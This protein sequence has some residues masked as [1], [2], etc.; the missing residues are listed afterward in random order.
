MSRTDS[1]ASR[2]ARL[3][4]AARDEPY[5]DRA[6]REHRLRAL[7]RLLLDN[8]TAIAEAIRRDFGHRSPAETRL[9]E[10]FPSHQAIRHA[11][12]HLKHWMRPQ[13]RRVSLWFQPSTAELRHQPLGAVGIMVPWNYPV[14]LAAAPLVAALAAGNRVLI[15]MSEFTPAT[16][17]LFAELVAGAFADDEFSVVEGDALVAREFAR[18]PFDHLLFTGS[19]PVGHQVMAA[20]ADNLTPVTLELG[21]K[22]PAIIGPGLGGSAQFA[23]AVE[24]IVVGKCLNAGQTCIA[25]D[26]VLVPAGQEQAFIDHA[27]K[28][29]GTCYPELATTPDYSSIVNDRQYQRLCSYLAD[30]SAGGARIVELAPGVPADPVMRRL[31][32]V[33]LLDARDDALVMREE[34]FGPLLPI[35]AYRDLAAAIGYVNR[36]PRPLALY[37]FDD[38]AAQIERVLAETV[39]GGVTINDTILHIAQDDLPFGGVGP[40]GMGCY[41]GFAGFETFSARK[42]VYRQSRVSAI[43]LFKPPYGKLFDRLTGILLR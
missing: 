11:L 19:T 33:A 32:P 30:A 42:G 16:S 37:Y 15:K 20:A 35:V 25:P 6:V 12:R 13:S 43:G 4:Q 2:F 1:L 9:L 23:R 29:I 38:D 40:S 31:P 17:A 7:D 18:L 36:R 39:S 8:E 24:R 28:V 5:P 3:Q 27:R 10:L 22:S 41:H 34:I 21:G 26:Y 14:F